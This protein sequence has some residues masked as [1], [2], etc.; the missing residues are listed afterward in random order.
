MQRH[1]TIVADISAKVRASYDKKTP[2]R[3]S[4][5]STN[6]TRHSLA[7]RPNVIDTGPLCN[8]LSI[9]KARRTAL[10]EPNVP[11]DKLVAA[12]LPYGLVPPV[13]M[14]FPGITAG[15]GYAGTAGESSSFKHGF[16][17]RTINYVEMVLG[18]GDIVKASPTERVDLFDGAAGALGTLGVT[19]L[20]E[21]QLQEAKPFVSTTYHPVT[22]VQS[23]LSNL[24]SMTEDSSIDFLDAI[25]FSPTHGAIITGSLSTT[26]DSPKV[27]FSRP[28]DPWFYLHVQQHTQP[29]STSQSSSQLVNFS[30]PLPSYLFR[31]DRGGFWV[32]A[33]AF[34]YMFFPFTR[35]TRWF[36]DDFLH[37]RM[38]YRALHASAQSQRYIIQD[39]AMPYSSAESFIDWTGKELGVWPL[40]LCPLK[41][42]VRSGT[43]HPHTEAKGHG[44]EEEQ[45][46]NVGV[47]GFGPL[48]RE[49]FVR[50]NRALEKKLKEGRGMKWFYAQAYYSEEEFWTMYNKPWYETLRTKYHATH[51]PSVWDKIR[52]DVAGETKEAQTSWKMWA[53]RIWPL[54]GVW[55]IIRAM[56]SGDW[57]IP[58]RLKLDD[59][60]PVEDGK[61]VKKD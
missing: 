51:L 47:W 7:K 8:V 6:S 18:N 4:H 45:L 33:S 30:V 56:Q 34:K 11:M 14:E 38:L 42:G 37:T 60:K 54:A 44:E 55:G 21:L 17:D 3:I 2:F 41:Q 43:F 26:A 23:A 22:S 61:M 53:L 10:V 31:Y 57:R 39:L 5:G 58:K 36:L 50:Q 13:V 52:V 29:A 49:E 40:W 24:Q 16:F 1:T 46:I 15:G 48:N 59:I 19:T 20:L 28:W 27:S 12:T 35:L 9:D 25:M 32:G